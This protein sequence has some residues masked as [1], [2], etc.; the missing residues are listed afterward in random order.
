V[1]DQDGSMLSLLR[2]R[3]YI[4]MEK[5]DLA[6]ARDFASFWGILFLVL[7]IV[8]GWTHLSMVNVLIGKEITKTSCPKIGV[9][10]TAGQENCN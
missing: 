5:I 4:W 2:G 9:L 1:I 3:W 7:S 10:N 8:R 6:G